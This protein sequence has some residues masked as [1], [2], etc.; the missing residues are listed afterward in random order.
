MGFCKR[1]YIIIIIII[2]II[3]IIIIIIIIIIFFFN[4][5]EIILV[6]DIIALLISVLIDRASVLTNGNGNFRGLTL[7]KSWRDKC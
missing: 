2:I 3:T 5:A 6:W 4:L 7:N 1:Y